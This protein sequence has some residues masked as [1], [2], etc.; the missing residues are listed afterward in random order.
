VCAAERNEERVAF[1]AHL[2]T[3]V[4]LERTAQQLSVRVERVR[5]CLVPDGFDGLRRPFDVGEQE[6]DS[7]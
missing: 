6:R 3:A 5:V 1:G 2:V 4:R 7:A